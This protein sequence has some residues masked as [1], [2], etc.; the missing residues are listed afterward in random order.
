MKIKIIVISL[1]LLLGRWLY[2]G[3]PE[4]EKIKAS[5]QHLFNGYC[6]VVTDEELAKLGNPDDVSQALIELGGDE[7]GDT[8]IRAKALSSLSYFPFEKVRLFLEQTAVSSDRAIFKKKALRALAVGF[9]DDAIP[10][11]N[12]F[13]ADKDPEIREEAIVALGDIGTQKSLEA[14]N[15]HATQENSPRN[16]KLLNEQVTKIT[17]QLGN[18]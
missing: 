7:S 14:L 10:T 4:V 13:L 5:L 8:I 12:L 15:N 11:L 1:I 18:K 9:K 17:N 2:A 3:T 6:L 16:L